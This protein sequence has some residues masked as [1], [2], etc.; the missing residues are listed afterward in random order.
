M[1]GLLA[2]VNEGCTYI[3]GISGGRL[4]PPNHPLVTPLVVAD[5]FEVSVHFTRLQI[6]MSEV[7]SSPHIRCS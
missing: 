7:G 3:F 6:V 2:H 1:L 4:N 5:S